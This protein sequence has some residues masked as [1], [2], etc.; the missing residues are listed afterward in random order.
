MMAHNLTRQDVADTI[1][2]WIDAGGRVKPTVL[3]S[4]RDRQGE[5]AYEMKPKIGGT[6]WYIKVCIEDRDG[7]DEGLALLSTHPDHG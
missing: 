4:F 3:H 7:P 6:T 2:E 5:T 1:V